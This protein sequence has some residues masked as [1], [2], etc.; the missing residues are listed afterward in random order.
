MIGKNNPHY[1]P[2][3]TNEE[4]EKGRN[5]EGYSKFIKTIL[6]RDNYTCQC[7]GRNIELEVHHLYSYSKHKEL[8]TDI[9]NGI[10]L[11]RKCH[12]IFHYKYG[13][14]ENTKKQFEEF[15]IKY[16]C[17]TLNG[18]SI[19]KECE[20]I[21]SYDILIDTYP[22]ER[23]ET[24]TY[25]YEFL[26]KLGYKINSKYTLGGYINGIDCMPQELYD[27][28]L[29]RADKKME[30]YKVQS[31]ILKGE[32]HPSSRKVII[33]GVI[34][35]NAKYVAEK[36]LNECTSTIRSMLNHSRKMKPNLYN[37]GLRYVDEPIESYEV[38]NGIKKGKNH[39][40]SKKVIC[41]N[42]IFETVTEC[43]KQYGVDRALISIY[44]KN[45]YKMP[46][47]WKDR[48]LRYATEKDII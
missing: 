24:V 4:R 42:K 23:F 34:Y 40:K 47:K 37:R 38:Q 43:A 11:C 5:I 45:D 13:Q 9:N 18:T 7:C 1:N 25:V 27:L 28:G 20:E 16:Y 22:N 29:H 26:K 3:L 21:P 17:K 39:Y 2:N 46:Q 33:D 19:N 15:L 44:L 10:T 30:D 36:I 31:G 32:N 48:G 41:D 8:A 14:G 35:P 6:K 12:K